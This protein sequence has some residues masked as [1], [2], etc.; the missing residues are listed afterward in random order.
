MV[1]LVRMIRGFKLI[2]NRVALSKWRTTTVW[3][4]QNIKQVMRYEMTTTP[5]K[6]V[7]EC[8]KIILQAAVP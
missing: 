4:T 6:T 2:R 7:S 3:I 1:S 5:R 8:P